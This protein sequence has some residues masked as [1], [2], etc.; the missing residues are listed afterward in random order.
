MA[1]VLRGGKTKSEGVEEEKSLLGLCA[2]IASRLNSICFRGMRSSYEGYLEDLLA[3]LVWSLQGWSSWKGTQPLLKHSA[4]W[5]FWGCFNIRALHYAV[6]SSLGPHC[7]SRGLW[8]G[9]EMLLVPFSPVLLKSPV[10]LLWC[11]GR[12]EKLTS[13][14]QLGANPAGAF[15]FL[16]QKEHTFF[17]ALLMVG[18]F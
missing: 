11:I 5:C 9:W 18:F 16:F 7:E 13:C 6:G 14:Q 3:P 10:T 2:C 17:G 4:V 15:P 8:E 12:Q 1:F